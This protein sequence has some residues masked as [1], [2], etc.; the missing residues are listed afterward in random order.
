MGAAKLN[1]HGECQEGNPSA[2]GKNEA[3]LSDFHHC[4]KILEKI[5]LKEE[6]FISAH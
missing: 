6:R 3:V 2:I 1:E 5:N 4:D